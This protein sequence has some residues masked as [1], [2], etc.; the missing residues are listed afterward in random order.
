MVLEMQRQTP[1]QVSQLSQDLEARLIQY[2]YRVTFNHHDTNDIVQEC[3][4]KLLET[5]FQNHS[6]DNLWPWLRQMASRKICDVWKK[7]K[8]EKDFLDVVSHHPQIT[9]PQPLEKLIADE[10]AQR[11]STALAALDP[12]HRHVIILRVY[13]GLNFSEIAEHLNRSS[14]AAKMLYSRAKTALKKQLARNG[15]GM[16]GMA[17]ALTVYGKLTAQTHAAVT[18]ITVTPAA[19]Q[20]GITAGF[21][22][23]V[24]SKLGLLLLA[25]A[26]AGLLSV[27]KYTLSSQTPQQVSAGATFTALD[28]SAA[29]FFGQDPIVERWYYYA[30]DAAASLI[31]RFIARESKDASGYCRYIYT[32]NQ[33]FAFNPDHQTV[34]LVNYRPFNPDLSVLRLPTDSPDLVQFLD[35]VEQRT[36]TSYC[37][38]QRVPGLCVVEKVREHLSASSFSSSINTKL[39]VESGF[40]YP[41]SVNT[42][43]VDARDPRHRRGWTFFRIDGQIKGQMVE[44]RGRI[45]FSSEHFPEHFPWLMLQVGHWQYVD[46]PQLSARRHSSDVIFTY[47]GGSF[48]VGMARPWTPLHTLDNIRRDAAQTQIPFSTRL[49]TPDRVEVTLRL[50][51][52]QLCYT[53]N[54][55]DD[56]I[57]SIRWLDQNNHPIGSLSFTYLDNLDEPIREVEIPYA[58]RSG[59]SEKTPGLCWLLQLMSDAGAVETK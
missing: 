42:Q 57:E 14:F 55:L 23:L 36:S 54:L 48:C 52:H 9:P 45:P 30:D 28:A 32:G 15:V 25:V 39:I 6:P 24:L 4:K 21:L 29:A 47:P 17:T 41:W 11:V 56:L 59:K 53:I 51:A 58:E 38:L 18:Q 49:V 33:T 10:L 27:G 35:T 20:T 12:D 13:E 22:T 16:V 37:A 50:D 34:Y 2:V 43:Q 5:F 19:L 26:T 1:E 46:T 3:K 40:L 7:R 31:L 44:G 8:R